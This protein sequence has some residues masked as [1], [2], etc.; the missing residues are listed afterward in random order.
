MNQGDA[1]MPAAEGGLYLSFSNVIQ[2]L[3]PDIPEDPKL[4]TFQVPALKPNQATDLEVPF[5]VPTAQKAGNYFVGAALYSDAT[6]YSKFNN[7]NP[8]LFG[9][10]GNAAMVVA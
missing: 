9:N 8:F 10:H 2:L 5:T 7:A 3:Q 1:P 4:A 6:E